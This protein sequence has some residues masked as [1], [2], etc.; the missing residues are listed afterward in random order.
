MGYL[1]EDSALSPGEKGFDQGPD[2]FLFVGDVGELFGWVGGW[3]DGWSR[4]ERGGLDALL[5]VHGVCVCGLERWRFDLVIGEWVEEKMSGLVGGWVCGWVGGRTDLEVDGGVPDVA[6][7]A[8]LAA[9]LLLGDFLLGD[10]GG[11]VCG[12]MIER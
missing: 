10:L 12:W 2:F 11:W 6:C 8:G 9:H 5:Y 7:P 1:S 4:G 3:V